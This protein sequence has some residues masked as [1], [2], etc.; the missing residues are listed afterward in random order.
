MKLSVSLAPG[1]LEALD[2]IV[3]REGLASRSAAIQVAIRRLATSSLTDAYADAFTDWDA[4]A[5]NA[6]WDQASA[7]GWEGAPG[8]AR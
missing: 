6:V 3:H 8:A 2:L 7:D 4:D 5:A 1:D